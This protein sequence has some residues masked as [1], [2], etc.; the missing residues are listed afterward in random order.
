MSNFNKIFNLTPAEINN[1]D[2][3]TIL[4]RLGLA[5]GFTA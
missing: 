1:L 2:R 5:S 3:D 4:K